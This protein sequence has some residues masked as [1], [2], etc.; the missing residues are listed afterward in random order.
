MEFEKL[1]AQQ[2]A[3]MNAEA[4]ALRNRE[5]LLEMVE[6][7]TALND[8]P[9]GDDVKIHWRRV[10]AAAAI[11]SGKTPDQALDVAN[12]MVALLF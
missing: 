11:E 6:K 12:E 8:K 1:T 2:W 7:I 9:G 5:I 3:D 4:L 10:F